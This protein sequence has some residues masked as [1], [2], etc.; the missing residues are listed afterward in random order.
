[1][2]K[3]FIICLYQG[4]CVIISETQFGNIYVKK[5]QQFQNEMMIIFVN[6]FNCENDEMHTINKNHW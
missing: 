2:G 1:M 5:N 4:T 6:S 3:M